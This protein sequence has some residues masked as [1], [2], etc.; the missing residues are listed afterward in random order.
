ML[1]AL[2]PIEYQ[3]SVSESQGILVKRVS[4]IGKYRLFS[5]QYIEENQ[6]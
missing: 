1:D 4:D 2:F 6:H 5:I 3:V